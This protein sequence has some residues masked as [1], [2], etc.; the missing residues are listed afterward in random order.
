LE[1]SLNKL[2]SNPDCDIAA[3]A[4]FLGP[5]RINAV[6]IFRERG[7]TEGPWLLSTSIDKTEFRNAIYILIRVRPF[8][9]A[10]SSKSTEDF[11]PKITVVMGK[12][13]IFGCR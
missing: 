2:E 12:I 8:A 1:K 7:I 10:G 4:Y 13:I 3:S 11:I 5:D 9:V 6:P